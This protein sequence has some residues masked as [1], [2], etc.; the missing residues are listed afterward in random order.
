MRFAGWT[1]SDGRFRGE[2][3]KRKG[4]LQIQS[5]LRVSM[6]QIA[7]GGIL[8]DVKIEITTASRHDES[9]LNGGRPDDFAFD[10]SF[11]MFEDGIAVITCFGE[12][13][14]C[15]G[16]EQNG[17]GTVDPDETQLAYGL[18]KCLRILAHLRGERFLGIARALAD[19][20]DSSGS[21]A[22]ENGAVFGESELAR[23]VLC[24]LPIGI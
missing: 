22:F 14:I 2:I 1:Q 5:N 13:G 10:Q 11:D 24:R 19:A 16:A 23:A 18:R 4:F 6:A 21:V 7:D 3:E 8:A 15:I 12:F 20:D 17:V 9:A